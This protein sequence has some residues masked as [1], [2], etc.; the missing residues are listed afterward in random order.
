[1]KSD[2][3]NLRWGYDG[4]GMACGPVEGSRIT[5]ATFID[6]KGDIFFVSMSRMGQY[7]SVHVSE[8]SLFD[9]HMYLAYPKVAKGIFERIEDNSKCQY[10]LDLDDADALEAIN[11]SDYVDEIKLVM[12]ANDQY[13]YMDEDASA[14]DWMMNYQN[15]TLDMSWQSDYECFTDD[16]GFECEDDRN[17]P[18][19]DDSYETM[20]RTF[21]RR[22]AL[23]TELEHPSVYTDMDSEA[24]KSIERELKK[25]KAKYN[26][27]LY[28]EWVK[29]YIAQEFY[30][31]KDENWVTVPYIFA[32]MGQYSKTFPENELECFRAWID[33]NGSAFMGEPAPAT[34]EEIKTAIALAADNGL[35]Y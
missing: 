14:D 35:E 22:L 18:E 1:M 5:E 4:G 6:E 8:V 31:H 25:L 3:V 20:E 19:S 15:G 7:A 29:T 9:L 32:G 17:V 33:G 23:E 26:D 10:D 28:T 27:F 13:C 30:N 12:I 16:E 21:K 2:L 24:Q 11:K 34:D